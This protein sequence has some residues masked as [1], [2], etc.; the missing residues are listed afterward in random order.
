MNGPKL[1][2]TDESTG[3]VVEAEL[4]LDVGPH[5]L[6]EVEKVWGPQRRDAAR[7]LARDKGRT[8]VPEHWHWDWR[9]K[10]TLLRFPTYRCIGIRCQDELQGIALIDADQYQAKIPPDRGKPLMYIEFLEVAPW[11]NSKL[12]DKR[13]FTPV[14]PRLVEAVIRFSEAE[15]FHGRIGLHSLPQ[16]ETFYDRCG[17]TKLDPDPKKENLH[18]YEMTRDQASDFLKKGGRP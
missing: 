18:Y 7:R 6:E 11:N 14:G 3:R 16:S 17:M 12:V 2:L 4:D 15:G 5:D 1:M 9:S 10:G 13:R 8:A